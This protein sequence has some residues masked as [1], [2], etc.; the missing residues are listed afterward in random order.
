MSRSKNSRKGSRKS[1]QIPVY[2]EPYD[3]EKLKQLYKQK[4]QSETKEN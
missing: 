1:K 4:K 2:Y 3:C